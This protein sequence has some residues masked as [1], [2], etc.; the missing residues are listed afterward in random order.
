MNVSVQE[1]CPSG[2]FGK[3]HFTPAYP[4]SNLLPLGPLSR[5]R[6]Q[7]MSTVTRGL[8]LSLAMLACVLAC[9]ETI[10]TAFEERDARTQ[11]QEELRDT[12]HRPLQ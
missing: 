6:R 12:P 11:E 4:A 5:K 10:A 1:V 3:L 8:L 9:I 2:L 7:H